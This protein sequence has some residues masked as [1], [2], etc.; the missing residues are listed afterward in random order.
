MMYSRLKHDEGA[1]ELVT[2]HIETS[3]YI[4][5]SLPPPR[6]HARPAH[7][8]ESHPFSLY[9]HQVHIVRY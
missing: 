1:Y 8:R 6:L 5:H 3:S 2:A 7:S 4:E 9:M